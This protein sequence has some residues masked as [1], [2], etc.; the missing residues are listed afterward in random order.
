MPTHQLSMPTEQCRGRE[1]E[2]PGGQLETNSSQQHAV[3]RQEF[4]PLDLA[5]EDGYL[6]A[7]SENL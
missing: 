2:P 6:M 4:G 1:E 5:A 7:K 3:G